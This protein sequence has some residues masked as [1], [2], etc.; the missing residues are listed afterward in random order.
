M[1]KKMMKAGF[2]V[3]LAIMTSLLLLAA[4]LLLGFNL[5]KNSRIAM[6]TL[7]DNR[8]LDI[9]NSAA[10]MLDGDVL[11]SLTAEDEDT[12]GYRNV[13]ETLAVFQDNIDLKYIYCVTPCDD[14]S[15]VFSVDPTVEDPGEFGSPVVTTPAL[16]AAAHGKSAVDEE[17]YSDAWGRFYS[18]Y[19]PVFDS[20]GMWQVLSLWI[21][22][23]TGTTII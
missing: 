6:K 18:S 7:I 2:S 9:S 16:V 21:F 12:E 19:S 4:N 23:R 17:A 10:D 20:R 14:D 5:M 13:S 3:R 15:F 11:E 1:D 22:P 8:M